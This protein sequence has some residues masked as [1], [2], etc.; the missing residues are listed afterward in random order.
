MSEPTSIVEQRR[1]DPVSGPFWTGAAEG[2]FPLQWCGDCDR[3][4][5]Y[6]RAR[7]PFCGGADLTWRDAS[8]RGTIHSFAHQPGREGD[9][10]MI[11]LVDLE[12]G[13]R[14][15]SHVVGDRA[16]LSVGSPVATTWTTAGDGTDLVTFELVEPA[17]QAG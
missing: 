16:G 14:L 5:H 3:P 4:H 10:T 13:P 11:V 7:C 15:L 2:R 12:E 9:G 17:E 6:P 8:G 1:T